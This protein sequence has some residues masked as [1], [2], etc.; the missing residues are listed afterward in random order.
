MIAGVAQVRSKGVLGGIQIAIGEKASSSYDVR[1]KLLEGRELCG[2]RR[3]ILYVPCHSIQ[4]F[5]QRPARRKRRVEIDGA[6]KRFDRPARVSQRYV[7]I[8]AL[9]VQETKPRMLLLQPLQGFQRFMDSVEA[10][11]VG[12]DQV[13]EVA[14][15]GRG[16]RQ[17]FRRRE[18]LEVVETLA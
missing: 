1:W 6:H 10:A 9:L 17:C 8:A 4:T 7:A 5:E 12:R 2:C 14:V 15:L 16:S 11:L 3:C 18:R 13:Q